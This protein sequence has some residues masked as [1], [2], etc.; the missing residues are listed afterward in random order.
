MK[1]RRADRLNCCDRDRSGRS[2]DGRLQWPIYL[3]GD[4]DDDDDRDLG[5][6]RANNRSHLSVCLYVHVAV[7]VSGPI[8][9]PAGDIRWALWRIKLAHGRDDTAL[10]F[11]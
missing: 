3:S 2:R 6:P 8:K 7:N 11:E 5:R 4:D 9:R 1:R 10:Y